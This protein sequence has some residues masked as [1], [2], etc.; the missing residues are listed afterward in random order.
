MITNIKNPLT[1]KEKS[2]LNAW[3]RWGKQME[4]LKAIDRELAPKR[5][6]LERARKLIGIN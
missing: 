3:H 5:A 2:S 1:N 6:E 4:F